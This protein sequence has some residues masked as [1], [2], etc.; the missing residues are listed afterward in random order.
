MSELIVYTYSGPDRASDVLNEVRS[1]K[2]TNVHKAL[3]GLEDAAVVTKDTD[4]KVKLRQ[5]MEAA[6]KGSTIAG[7][8][9]W[10]VLVGFLFGGP[11][12]GALFGLGIAALFGRKLDIGIDNAFMRSIGN[13][14]GTGD[15]ALLMLVHD[16]PVDTLADVMKGFGGTLHSA[17]LSK[18]AADAFRAVG[19]HEDVKAALSDSSETGVHAGA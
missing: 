11:L 8:G 3:I 12:L 9:L 16:T 17:T 1:L 15:S 10:G 4:G 14:L 2:T 18:E 13:D 5:T 7:G 19:E 6:V